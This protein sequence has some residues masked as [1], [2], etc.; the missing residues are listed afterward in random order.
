MAKGLVN[1]EQL[2]VY[3]RKQSKMTIRPRFSGTVPEIRLMSRTDFVPDLLNKLMQFEKQ[4][5]GIAQSV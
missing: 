3:N 1:G 2:H 5:I 4:G